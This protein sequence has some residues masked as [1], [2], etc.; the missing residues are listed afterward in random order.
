MMLLLS[1]EADVLMLATNG[2]KNDLNSD[3]K[4]VAGL[5]LC[6]IGN[7]ATADM[8]RDLAPEVDKHLKSTQPY[9]RKKACL[10]MARCL[11]KCPEMVED[12]VD[13]VVTLLKDRNH[14]VLITVVQLMTQVLIMDQKNMELEGYG[15]D[16]ISPCQDAFLRLVPSLVKL[17][18]NIINTNFLSFI[19][20]Q[21]HP[22]ST[23]RNP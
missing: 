18:R 4:F 10:A 12:F 5:S 22:L 9:L 6:A 11:T 16:E 19:C 3:N 15:D 8:S 21:K 2:L 17:L 1:E 14:G 23:L 20:N 7:L 13:R